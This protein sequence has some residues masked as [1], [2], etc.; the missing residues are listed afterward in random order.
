MKCLSVGIVPLLGF[1]IAVARLDS[2]LDGRD[3]SKPVLCSH[4]AEHFAQMTDIPPL[5]AF[6]YG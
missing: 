1:G 2:C 3:Q 6:L 4:T 5:L